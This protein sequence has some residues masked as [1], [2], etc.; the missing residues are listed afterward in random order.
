M[1]PRCECL[2]VIQRFDSLHLL[3]GSIRASFDI[4]AWQPGS[5]FLF[6]CWKHLLSSGLRSSCI[7][8]RSALV[9]LILMTVCALAL[10]QFLQGWWPGTKSLKDVAPRPIL[11]SPLFSSGLANFRQ[12]VA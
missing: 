12:M 11:A 1:Q 6:I 5:P 10:S 3:L 4:L 8:S 2:K 9:L 7:Q